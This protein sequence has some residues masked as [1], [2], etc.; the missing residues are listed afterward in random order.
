MGK[1]IILRCPIIPDVNTFTAHYDAIANI[2]N[3]YKGISQVHLEP[4]HPLG[5]EK[6]Q[7]LGR[8]SDYNRSEFLD[9]AEANK[10]CEY[11]K[12]KTS[13]PVMVN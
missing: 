9:K 11:I 12:G 1:E 7:A 3:E 4:Y 8:A 5:I 2:A 13:V 6:S 10:I